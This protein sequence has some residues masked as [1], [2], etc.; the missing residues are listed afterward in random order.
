MFATLT[1][2]CWCVGR[3]SMY[4]SQ[5]YAEFGKLV[6]Q[7]RKRLSM[8]QE[9]LGD[10]IGLSRASIANIETGRQHIP[11]HHLY[12]LARVLKVDPHALLPMPPVDS[13]VR[14]DREI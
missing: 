9:T 1:F 11:L 12:R 14:A 13:T 4:E 2:Q 10:E 6:R 3:R 7:H 5:L 8:N